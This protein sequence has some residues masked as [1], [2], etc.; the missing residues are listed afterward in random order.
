MS[1]AHASAFYC[2]YCGEEN[3]RPVP[4]PHGAWRCSDCLRTFAVTLI[5]IGV[6]PTQEART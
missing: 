6:P 1:D 3:L 4:E 2:P 5:G